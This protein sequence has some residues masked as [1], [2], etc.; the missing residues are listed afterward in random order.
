MKINVALLFLLLN[1]VAFVAFVSSQK[2]NNFAPGR[3]T[4]VHLFEWHWDNI[5]QE[6]ENFLAPKGYAGVQV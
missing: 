1:F 6:C 3:N 5:A 4:I 2:D